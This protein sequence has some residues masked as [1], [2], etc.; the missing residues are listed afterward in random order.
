MLNLL[1]HRDAS[2][3]VKLRTLSDSVERIGG[4]ISARLEKTAQKVLEMNGFDSETGSP[5]EGVCLSASITSKFY[6]L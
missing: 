3:A 2:E 5:K 1:Q 4:Q 6:R